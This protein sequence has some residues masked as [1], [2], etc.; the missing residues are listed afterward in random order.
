[1]VHRGSE[2]MGVRSGTGLDGSELQPELQLGDVVTI[3]ANDARSAVGGREGML[4]FWQ[5]YGRAGHGLSA[6]RRPES[7]CYRRLWP[8]WRGC[9]VART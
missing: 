7:G 5:G 8:D 2:G 9:Y 4:P 1:M 6:V 3:V